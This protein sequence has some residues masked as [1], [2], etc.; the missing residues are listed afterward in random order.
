MQD[1][2]GAGYLAL[3]SALWDQD[4]EMMQAREKAFAL[5]DLAATEDVSSGHPHG[6]AAA[7]QTDFVELGSWAELAPRLPIRVDF[8]G[9]AFRVVEIEGQPVAH[10]VE[11][12]HWLGPLDACPVEAGIVTC[13]WHGYRFEVA[14]GKSVAGRSLR[15]RPAPRL[16]VNS[17]TGAVRMLDR[18]SEQNPVG[19]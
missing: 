10:S 16:E 9:H 7:P 19:V 3:Y 15:L 1:R 18:R 14:T 11:C 5:R 4:E 13:P 17:R 12:P 6:S 8:G 2:V